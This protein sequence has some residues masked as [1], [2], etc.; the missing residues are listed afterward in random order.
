MN[1]KLKFNNKYEKQLVFNYNSEQK[2]KEIL[3][4]F[5]DRIVVEVIGTF[6]QMNKAVDTIN[7]FEQMAIAAGMMTQKAKS[8]YGI[9]E[10][11][12]NDLKLKYTKDSTWGEILKIC[13][14]QMTQETFEKIL[15]DVLNYMFKGHD[16]ITKMTA[17]SFISDII[18]EN[19]MELL[20]PQTSKKIAI[21]LVEVYSLSTV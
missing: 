8:K 4:K 6:S 9:S 1:T 15:P 19:K 11:E 12:L 3:N 5:L 2:M 20:K 14:D 10:G 18:L 21:K 13:R 17:I 16:L 7:K